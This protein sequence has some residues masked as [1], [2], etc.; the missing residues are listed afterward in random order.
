MKRLL[1]IILLVGIVAFGVFSFSNS[2]SAEEIKMVGVTT[3]IELAADG[4]S[5]IAVLKDTKSGAEISI[6]VNDELTLDKF[7][8]KRIVVDDEIRCRYDN[9][10]GKNLSKSFK[11]TAG[12]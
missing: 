9:E 3:K 11:K 1:S 2:A 7:K 8:D 6:L 4:K 5:A 10:S 12:C